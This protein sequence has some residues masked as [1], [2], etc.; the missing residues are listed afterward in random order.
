LPTN[1]ARAE[2]KVIEAE[3]TYVL[4]G[5][6]SKA[7]GRRL[8]TQ[9]AQRKALERAGI[10]LAGITQVK[11]FRLTKDQVMAYA[12][13]IVETEIIADEIRGPVDHPELYVKARCRVDTDVLVQQIGRYRESEELGELLETA[14]KEKEALRKERDALQKQLAGEQDKIRAEVTQKKLDS[15]LT[16]EEG[17]DDTSRAWI[18]LSPRIDFYG[19]KESRQEIPAAEI[20]AATAALQKAIT[21]NPS[22]VRARILLASVYD[23]RQDYAAAEEELR[24]ALQRVPNNALVHLRLG[25][26]LRE[27]GKLQEALREF[28]VI[29]HRRPNMPQMLFQT[30]LTHKAGGNCR[31]AVAYMK[32]LLMYTKNNDRPEIARLKPKAKAVIEDCGDQPVP[33]KKQWR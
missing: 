5:N 17:F 2:I 16:N 28:R 7:D 11:E 19:G 27:Q 25:I 29:E 3:S 6:D 4:G 26:V 8:A 31:L 13:G 10:Y 32:R 9:E 30:G 15:V 1:A 20:E 24:A 21:R 18:R 12:A 33:R 23:Q 22:N 14:A